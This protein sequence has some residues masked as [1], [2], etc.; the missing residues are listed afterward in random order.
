MRISCIAR[1]HLNYS[2]TFCQV[3]IV[4]LHSYKCTADCPPYPAVENG[5]VSPKTPI[6]IGQSVTI[7]CDAGF[8]PDP[9]PSGGTYQPTCVPNASSPQPGGGGGGSYTPGILCRPISCGAYLPPV[10][11]SVW[12][13]GPI[14]FNQTVAIAC[15]PGFAPAGAGSA[16]PRCHADGSFGLGV[17]CARVPLVCLSAVTQAGA[18]TAAARTAPF[19]N[20]TCD[21]SAA[22][23]PLTLSLIAPPHAHTTL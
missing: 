16:A 1:H 11:G 14:L 2:V 15:D 6:G 23:P 12:P 7:L 4:I 9:G 22:P 20:R 8:A 18:D 19:A 17:G 10:D 3:L 21:R 13:T 5:Q